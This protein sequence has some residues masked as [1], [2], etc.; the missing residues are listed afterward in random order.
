MIVSCFFRDRVH[1]P[2][3]LDLNEVRQ[4]HECFE[5]IESWEHTSDMAKTHCRKCLNR[6]GILQCDE[7]GNMMEYDD[8]PVVSLRIPFFG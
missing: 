3:Q 2:L 7:T 6:F 5:F 4:T 8:E 1:L